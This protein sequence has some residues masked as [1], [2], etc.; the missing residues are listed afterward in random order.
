MKELSVLSAFFALMIATAGVAKAQQATAGQC[1]PRD[2]VLGQLTD[3]YGETRRAA[4]LGAGKVMELFASE[5]TGSWTITV[6]TASGMTCLVA[7]GQ[8]FQD[9]AVALPGEGA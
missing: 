9:I 2:T 6:T 1:G 3:R 7:A 8:A 5:K 4:G